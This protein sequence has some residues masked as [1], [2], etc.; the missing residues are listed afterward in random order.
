MTKVIKFVTL[1]GCT[2]KMEAATSFE[3]LVSYRS[4]PRRHNAEED[5]DLNLHRVEKLKS[6]KFINFIRKDFYNPCFR[7]VAVFQTVTTM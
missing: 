2:L 6:R 1:L 7:Y 4:N 3:T 5:L